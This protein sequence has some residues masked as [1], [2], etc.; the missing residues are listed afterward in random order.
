MKSVRIDKKFTSEITYNNPEYSLFPFQTD[1]PNNETF[2]IQ[3]L[4]CATEIFVN[5]F[6][7]IWDMAIIAEYVTIH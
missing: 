3:I 1:N 6:L 2:L 4:T 7:T 5:N